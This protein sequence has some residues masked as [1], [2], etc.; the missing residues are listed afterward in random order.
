[1]IPRSTDPHIGAFEGYRMDWFITIKLFNFGSLFTRNDLNGESYRKEVL[2]SL[3]RNVSD[4]LNLGKRNLIWV[5]CSE[6][7]MSGLGH[8]HALFSFDNL[9]VIESRR[10]KL[11]HC[12]QFFVD[13]IIQ[14]FATHIK[15]K[16]PKGSELHLVPVTDGIEHSKRVLSYLMKLEVGKKEKE[17]FMPKWFKA[18]RAEKNWL[19]NEEDSILSRDFYSDSEIANG[20]K[21]ILKPDGGTEI[22]TCPANWRRGLSPKQSDRVLSFNPNNELIVPTFKM[23]G[24]K[25]EVFC[26][27]SPRIQ[28]RI[29]L[30]RG[31]YLSVAM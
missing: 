24:G 30:F 3:V 11:L 12:E 19:W 20:I 29:E 18:R 14:S 22:R 9:R 10:E 6:F 8:L 21:A 28:G 26:T 16:I 7:G 2:L 15:N 25:V 23:V 5:G 13:A 27:Y 1:M 4:R 17:V 31:P